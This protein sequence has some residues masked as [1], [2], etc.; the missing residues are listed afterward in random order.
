MKKAF[1]DAQDELGLTALAMAILGGQVDAVIT[2]LE[3]GA[4]ADLADNNGITPLMRAFFPTTTLMFPVA[5]RGGWR[6][7]DRLSV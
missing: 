1:M 5:A 4:S 3:L 2:L 7:V 6:S